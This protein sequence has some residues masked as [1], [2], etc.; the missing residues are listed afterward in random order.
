M[1]L[2]LSKRKWP[3]CANLLFPH[4]IHCPHCYTLFCLKR[5]TSVYC[6][7]WFPSALRQQKVQAEDRD[8]IV[9]PVCS[10]SVRSLFWS[11]T[12]AVNSVFDHYSYRV[13]PVLQSQ[14]LPGLVTA[15]SLKIV[16]LLILFSI[17]CLLCCFMRRS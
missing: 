2:H 13:A 16:I 1:D 5:L 8:W 7:T 14:L 15:S 6:I 10:P 17:L 4:Q 11:L 12:S 9:F 3:K